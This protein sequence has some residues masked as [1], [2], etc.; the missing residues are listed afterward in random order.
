LSASAFC[1]LFLDLLV[2]IWNRNLFGQ[3]HFDSL[4]AI[5]DRAGSVLSAADLLQAISTFGD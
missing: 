2:E 1:A 4:L 5:R 3:I